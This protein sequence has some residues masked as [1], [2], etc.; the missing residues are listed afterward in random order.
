MEQWKSVV[1]Y[2]GF[3]E[4]SNKGMLRN[5][6]GILKK[7]HVD[8]G[9]CYVH[10]HREGKHKKCL[11]H[12]LVAMAFIANPLNKRCVNHLDS[13]RQNNHVENLE[14]CTHSENNKHLY[15]N[16]RGEKTRSLARVRMKEVNVRYKEK[17]E[18]VKKEN[19]AKKLAGVDIPTPEQYKE[20]MQKYHL[21]SL[22]K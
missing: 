7:F 1:G 15:A 20:E 8:H 12:R 5:A 18:A 16:G 3:Y 19:R 13:N 4:V 10:L 17:R 2:E 14:W 9:Y 21:V 11:M 6:K 22:V